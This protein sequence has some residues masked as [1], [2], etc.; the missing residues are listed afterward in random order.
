[1]NVL[2]NINRCTGCTAC[3]HSCP[4]HC[5][6]MVV[7]ERGFLYPQI[8]ICQCTQCDI[9]RTICPENKNKEKLETKKAPPVYAAK[10]QNEKIRLASTSG[11]IFTALADYVIK[12]KGVVFGAK[13]DQNFNVIHSKATTKEE[14][15]AFRGSKYVQSNLGNIFIKIKQTLLNGKIV[16]F[17]GSPCQVSGLSSYLKKPY[18]NLITCDFI[19]HG[20]PSPGIWKDY[21]GHME[22][23]FNSILSHFS[24][25]D[26]IYGWHKPSVKKKFKNGK[27]VLE[28]L[29][30]EPF[31]FLFNT[32]I[33]L[34]DICHSCSYTNLNRPAD[35][36]IGD[37]WK[38]DKINNTFDD[39]KG[40]SQILINSKQGQH[41]FDEIKHEIIYFKADLN[42]S[43]QPNLIKPTPRND[44]SKTFWN[45][46]ST[47]G[48]EFILGKYQARY[49]FTKNILQKLRLLN[50]V[51]NLIK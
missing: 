4:R 37:F 41:I 10:H 24:F 35:L 51:E 15:I 8:S 21:V 34:R 19:C 18:S 20:V 42:K 50:F 22:K 26:K 30:N 7:N 36:T 47:K 28:L 3:L 2:N 11:G 9:C 48:F 25:R 32:N 5:I 27:K 13:F 6:T 49:R 29:R 16:L 1:M 44:L 14:C 40:V 39:N 23:Q 17:T 38:I 46:Y 12:N 31:G 43:L 45:D 33:V